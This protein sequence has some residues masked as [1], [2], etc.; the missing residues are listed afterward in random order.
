MY[1]RN[2][3]YIVDRQSFC[4]LYVFKC[5]CVFEYVCKG[6]L[7]IYIYHGNSLTTYDYTAPAFG[8][9]DSSFNPWCTRT[10]FRVYITRRVELRSRAPLN[11]LVRPMLCDRFDRR[12]SR[13]ATR[14]Y[15][16]SYLITIEYNRNWGCSRF[17]GVGIIT[18][19]SHEYNILLFTTVIN[20]P[21]SMTKVYVSIRGEMFFFY[22]I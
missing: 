14:I 20:C 5:V 6:T 7:I 8:F 4:Y 12:K 15:L 13:T 22:L 16:L 11:S 2:I 19:I 18:T 21:H 1:V 10:L 17:R 9:S 3:L